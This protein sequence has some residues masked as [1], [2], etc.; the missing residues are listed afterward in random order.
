MPENLPIPDHF[1]YGQIMYSRLNL[2]R[3]TCIW[4]V[5]SVLLLFFSLL[6]A[7][8][9]FKA[10]EETPILPLKILN[11]TISKYSIIKGNIGIPALPTRFFS[12]EDKEVAAHV[13]FSNVTGEHTFRWDWYS[14]DG[15]L[16]LTSGNH[17]IK[18]RPGK[19][20]KEGTVCH[21]LPLK[22]SNAVTHLG[23]WTLKIYLDDLEFEKKDFVIQKETEIP[24][25]VYRQIDFGSYHALIIGN[26]NYNILRKLKCAASDAEAVAKLLVE[27]YKFE[28]NLKLD[29]TR[30]EIIES[31]DILRKTLG[32]HDN[33]LIYYAGHGYLDEDEDN[34][35]W[36]PVDAEY[37]I[38]SNWISISHIISKIRAMKA[39]HVLVVADSCF[40]GKWSRNLSRTILL[41]PSST[42]AGAYYKR[43]AAKKAR[44]VLSSGGLEEVLDGAGNGNHSVFAAAFIDALRRNE[45]VID[46]SELYKSILPKVTSLADQTPEYYYIPKTGHD[47][48]EFL[49]VSQQALKKDHALSK[50]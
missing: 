4:G 10:K 17:A 38:S 7:C 26:N 3:M 14:P 8:S 2:I 40:S 29:A 41:N 19:Y 39:K 47:G 45:Q 28:V 30:A 49:F 11:T 23:T 13:T 21:R 20:H 24:A 36:L 46:G 22:G 27:K 42:S 1:L 32:P 16:Y 34:G 12:I 37:E 5:R 44:K 18:V 35:Y 48:G 25:Y 33:L 31:L 9:M 43:L 50:K 6:F 15:H